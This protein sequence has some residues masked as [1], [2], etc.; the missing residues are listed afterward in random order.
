[1]LSAAGD[2]QRQLAEVLML[3]PLEALGKA[4]Q[5]LTSSLSQGNQVTKL[6]ILDLLSRC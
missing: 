6:M 3:V 4:A 1:M 5:H 2:E